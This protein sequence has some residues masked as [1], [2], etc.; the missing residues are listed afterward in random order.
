VIDD[1]RLRFERTRIVLGRRSTPVVD[2]DIPLAQLDR[3]REVTTKTPSSQG[4]W[5]VRTVLQFPNG[6]SID[7]GTLGGEGMDT[8]YGALVRHLR[9]RLGDRFE[10]P[11]VVV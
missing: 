5:N 8:A 10:K 7:T 1:R 3:V 9:Q 2:W 4:G 11:P 6:K